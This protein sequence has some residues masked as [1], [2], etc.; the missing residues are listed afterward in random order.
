MRKFTLMVL[1]LGVVL[2]AGCEG[3]DPVGPGGTLN[4]VTGLA[5]DAA[6]VGQTVVLTWDAYQEKGPEAI[7]GYRLFFHE[8]ATGTYLEI[9]DIAAGTTTYSHTASA[10]GMY[11]IEAYEGENTSANV[12]ETHTLPTLVEDTYTIWNNHAPAD[13]HSG[14]MFGAT[15][16]TTGSAASAAFPQ[17]VYCYDGGQG[18]LTW[19]YSGDY[20]TFGNGHHTD[21][22]DGTASMPT[23]NAWSHGAMVVGDVIFGEL[24]TGYYVKVYIDAL[25]LY[26]GGTSNAYGIQFYY[27]YQPIQGLY[28]F[29]TATS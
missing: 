29:T 20:G 22:F 3:D 16:G 19:L 4:D 7:D 17:D 1:A 8:N 23:S 2:M 27:D 6:S 9:A 12:D 28:L 25:P 21:M 14:F 10:A 24:S 11:A 13:T 18:N 26:V 5:V 15:S